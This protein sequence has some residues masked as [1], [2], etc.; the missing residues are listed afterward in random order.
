[1][2]KSLKRAGW[3]SKSVGIPD[4]MLF[5]EIF[6]LLNFPFDK[7][8]MKISER[9][10]T[11]R[12]FPDPKRKTGNSCWKFS[13]WMEDFLSVFKAL[14]G[15]KHLSGK[16]NKSTISGFPPPVLGFLILTDILESDINC[17]SDQVQEEEM[18]NEFGCLVSNSPALKDP[19]Y[20]KQMQAHTAFLLCF[21]HFF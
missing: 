14:M 7:R 11:V 10:D 4:L 1:M 8:D 9:A 6:S 5:A 3:F 13:C 18:S 12:N 16:L 21:F 2:C 19:K 15:Q 20:P 17:M